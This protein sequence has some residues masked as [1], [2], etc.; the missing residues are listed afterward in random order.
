MRTSLDNL[1][2]I[3]FLEKTKC[4]AR[5]DKVRKMMTK[6]NNLYWHITLTDV[7]ERSFIILVRNLH[8]IIYGLKVTVKTTYRSRLSIIAGN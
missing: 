3:D 6:F 8:A 7:H 2:G 4:E 1:K 5:H